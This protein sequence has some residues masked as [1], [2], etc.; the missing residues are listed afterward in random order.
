MDGVCRDGLYSDSG[1]APLNPSSEN[2][3][4]DLAKHPPPCVDDFFALWGDEAMDELAYQQQAARNG[5]DAP[6]N[7]AVPPHK[8]GRSPPV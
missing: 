2:Q 5:N 7:I 8:R 1:T 6:M 3:P 4:E